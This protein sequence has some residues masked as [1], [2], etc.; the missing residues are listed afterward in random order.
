MVAVA[1]DAKV[2]TIWDGFQKYFRSRNFD[3]DY[4]LFSNYE[5]QVEA[6]VQGQVDVAWNSPLAWLQAERAAKGFAIARRFE[7]EG[8]DGVLSGL[9]ASIDVIARNLRPNA[10]ALFRCNQLRGRE[11]ADAPTTWVATCFAIWGR[12]TRGLGSR[13]GCRISTHA[14]EKNRF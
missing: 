1:Y 12:I 6:Q 5:K 11:Q 10:S 3:F 14:P 4:I 2:V 7:P 8:E 9:R 13:L